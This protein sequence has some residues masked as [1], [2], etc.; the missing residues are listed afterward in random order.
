[1]EGGSISGIVSQIKEI[2]CSRLLSVGVSIVRT[3]TLGLSGLLLRHLD[4]TASSHYEY[5]MY[6]STASPLCAVC[7]SLKNTINRTN[8]SWP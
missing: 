6:S 8:W 1:M 7:K 3:L 2:G 5:L 4:K